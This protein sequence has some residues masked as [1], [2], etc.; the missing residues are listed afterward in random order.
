MKRSSGILMH[1]TSLPSPYGIGDLGPSAYEFID[2]LEIS[3][4]TVWQILPIN[5]TESVFGHSPYSSLSAFAFNHLLISPAKLLQSGYL[6]PSDIGA[7]PTFP[8]DHVN[9][10]M[11][12]EFKEKIFERAFENFK[13]KKKADESYET[14]YA[15]NKQWLEDYSLFIIL[16]KQFNGQSWSQWPQEVMGY[17]YPS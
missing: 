8:D 9:Y 3:K 10:D 1:V 15:N 5:Q 2:F 17:A 14:F 11:V 12:I 6:N 16:K 13:S 7:I 4:Q